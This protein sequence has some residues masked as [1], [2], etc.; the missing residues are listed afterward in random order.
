[1]LVGLLLLFVVQ[2]VRAMPFADDS[3]AC[4]AGLV[5]RHDAFYS[6]V[7]LVFPERA[8]PGVHGY[9]GVKDCNMMGRRAELHLSGHVFDVAVADCLGRQHKASHETLWGETWLADV[10]IKL[11][12]DAKTPG[13]PT[14][15]VLCY[16]SSGFQ[17]NFT[18]W[19]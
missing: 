2:S 18:N 7:L 11:W 16:A 17:T 13:R 6:S 4:E 15:A 12:L 3:R 10:D 19:P 14:Q 1:M 8:V 5:T 9:I